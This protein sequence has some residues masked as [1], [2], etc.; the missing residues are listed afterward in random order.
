MGGEKEDEG[1]NG[2]RKISG[3]RI[4]VAAEQPVGERAEEDCDSS[5]DERIAEGAHSLCIE[6]EEMAEGE[7]VIAGVLFEK[8]GEVGVGG[9]GVGVQDEEA[10]EECGDRSEDKECD[11]DALTGAGEWVGDDEG[12]CF[13][14]FIVEPRGDEKNERWE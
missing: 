13:A 1:R 5:E 7:S 2:H 12:F 11:R 3:M 14:G 10:G 6:V 8:S 9:G 4:V